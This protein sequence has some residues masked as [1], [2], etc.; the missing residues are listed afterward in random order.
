MGG[1]IPNTCCCPIHSRINL[2]RRDNKN[3]GGVLTA[4]IGM[5]SHS[6]SRFFRIG[7]GGGF[8]GD[9][10]LARID[11]L[12]RE[13]LDYLVMDYLAELTLSIMT[14]Q[15]GRN[16][17]AGW[18]SDLQ[19]WLD[20]GGIHLLRRRGVK[21]V[22]NA[23]GANPQS[24]AR[25]VLELADRTG[26][27]DCRVAVV[28]GDD[29]LEAIPDLMRSGEK[30]ENLESGEKLAECNA[31][32]LSANAYLG[33]GPIASALEIGADIVI[34]GRVADAS[35]IVGSMLHAA[36]WSANAFAR[37][38]SRHKAV[39]EWAPEG[40]ENPLDTLAMWTVAGHLIE[41][42]AQVSGGNSTDWAEIPSLA[43][44]TLPIAEVHPD[45]RVRI[46]RASGTGGMVNRRI[47]AEQLVYEI[48]NPA[49][50]KTPDVVCD[51]R[52][53]TIEDAGEDVVVV[54]G[55]KGLPQPERLKVSAA[56]EGGWFASSALM[57]S[58]PNTLAR[59]MATDD[60]LRGR[61]TDCDEMEIHTEFIG[62]GTTLPI[63]IRERFLEIFSP[64]E[65][66][67]RWA[68]TTPEKADITRFSREIAPLVLTGPAG[69]GG[70]GSRASPRRQLR[71]WPCLIERS[72]VEGE[73]RVEVLT[74]LKLI[75]D[76]ERFHYIRERT[77]RLL[78]RLHD[79]LDERQWT[80][81]IA[82]R[83]PPSRSDERRSTQSEREVKG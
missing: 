42:G 14:K 77:R 52:E 21:L 36:G 44:L 17:D 47:V 78:D 40:H 65:V 33:A 45:G 18:A 64:P 20:A 12:K 9:R 73:V 5:K 4:L 19:L 66:M 63:A 16:P 68:V 31:T 69:V 83:L 11:L 50:Y 46:T 10:P 56:V 60:A 75:Q 13:E 54:G 76:G 57:V 23:G 61:L 26:W 28:S 55:A 8:W 38:I 29:M 27:H 58:G 15:K 3:Q 82:R 32:V 35:L 37:D 67:V 7:S 71:F 30:F 80:R 1:V 74:H 6:D 81:P 70:Y 49:E 39:V 72:A 59:A 22:T 51:L 25:M 24:C 34:T 43:N 62:A 79:E 53:V 48:G 2:L 41:C